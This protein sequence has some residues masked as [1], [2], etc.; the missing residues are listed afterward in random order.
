LPMSS[1]VPATTH[2]NVWTKAGGLAE[3]VNGV[4]SNI[5]IPAGTVVDVLGYNAAGTP[6]NAP[7]TRQT[8]IRE[9]FATTAAAYTWPA[10][11][12]VSD[13]FADVYSVVSLIEVTAAATITLSAPPAT[14]SAAMIGVE[15]DIKATGVWIGNATIAAAATIDGAASFVMPK[16]SA[17]RFPSISVRW[18]GAKWLVV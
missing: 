10:P 8:V 12:V 9:A 15:I 2:V 5:A 7:I 11:T 1:I 14:I 18:T 3:S 17:T 6:V 13:S 4:P 16:T